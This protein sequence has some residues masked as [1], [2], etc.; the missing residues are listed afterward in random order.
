MAQANFLLRYVD[1]IVNFIIQK[2]KNKQKVYK[3]CKTKFTRYEGTRGDKYF[4]PGTRANTSPE[5]PKFKI[6]ASSNIF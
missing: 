3:L 4:A 1:I 2:L 5:S 6:D